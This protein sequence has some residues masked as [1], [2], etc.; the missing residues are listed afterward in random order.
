EVAGGS[1]RDKNTQSL[2]EPPTTSRTLD[3]SPGP[4]RE[5][6]DLGRREHPDRHAYHA[7]AATH[8]QL[9]VPALEMPHHVLRDQSPGRPPDSGQVELPAVNV[10]GERQRDA[11]RGGRVPRA[12]SVREQDLERRRRRRAQRGGDA[13]RL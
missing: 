1:L 12:W 6:L 4:Q 2:R 11:P 7:D 8:V 10:P 3:S 13:C 9:A 5:Q